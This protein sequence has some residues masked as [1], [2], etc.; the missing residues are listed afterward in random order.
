M[1][2]TVNPQITDAVARCSKCDRELEHY[3]TFLA[4][5]GEERVVC[6]ECQ[7]RKE[8]GF[9]AHRDFRRQARSGYIPR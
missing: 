3:N 1:P 4:P 8:K 5:D 2:D 7:E 9:N 6:S